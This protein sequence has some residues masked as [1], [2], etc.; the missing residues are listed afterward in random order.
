M[1]TATFAGCA[2]FLMALFVRYLPFCPPSLPFYDHIRGQFLD[3]GHIE[4]CGF[5]HGVQHVPNITFQVFL[6]VVKF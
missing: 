1:T 2:I 4:K 6:A 5:L 3:Q